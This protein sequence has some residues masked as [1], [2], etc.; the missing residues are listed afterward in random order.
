MLKDAG[1]YGVLYGK[2]YLGHYADSYFPTARSFDEFLVYFGCAE[3]H[4]HFDDGGPPD[5]LPFFL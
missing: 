3:D 1:Y 2:W 4:S 5:F